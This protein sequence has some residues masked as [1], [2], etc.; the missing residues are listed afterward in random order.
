[1]TALLYDCDR[2][3]LGPALA[4]VFRPLQ[5]DAAVEAWLA[6]WAARPHGWLSTKV[7]ELLSSFSSSYDVHGRLG[8]YPMHLLS[9]DAWGDLLESKHAASLLDVGA[10]AGYVTEG[11]RRWFDQIVCTETSAPLVTRLLE[12]G[13]EAQRLDLTVQWLAR[14]FD[15]VSAFNVLDRTDR[16]LSLLRALHAHAGPTGTILLSMPLP[17]APHVHVKGGT[18]SPSERLPSVAASWEV[19]ARELSERLIEPVGLEVVRLAR[20]P[21]LSRG[22]SHAPLYVLDAAVWVCRARGS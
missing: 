4:A 1:M 7:T 9:A 6:E 3:R 16:P 19:A 10:G 17:P 12:R 5:R 15:V 20:A 22:D 14:T 2:E 21:Y 11:A 18:A 8:V 13:F